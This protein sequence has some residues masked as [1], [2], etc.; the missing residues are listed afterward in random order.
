MKMPI[1]NALLTAFKAQAEY[2]A[3]Q[4]EVETFADLIRSVLSS[5][6]GHIALAQDQG[7]PALHPH[8]Y[9]WRKVQPP[10]DKNN[11]E[12]N[13]DENNQPKPPKPT[14]TP[15]G[16]CFGWLWSEDG[17][18]WQIWLEP[19]T[20]YRLAVDNARRS[21]EHFLMSSGTLWRRMDNRGLLLDIEKQKKRHITQRP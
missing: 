8:R 20:T 11:D 9:G 6:H 5:G 17:E 16:D 2:Q 21:G 19:K 18:D 12:D 14:Y 4:D 15:L 7:P 13:N 10:M 1:E 3:E